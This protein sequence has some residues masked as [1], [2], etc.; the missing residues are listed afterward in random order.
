MTIM[1]TG[2]GIQGYMNRTW[3][4][5]DTILGINQQFNLKINDSL[6]NQ[7]TQSNKITLRDM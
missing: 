4:I 3:Y 5:E 6:V 1:G 7:W 2:D